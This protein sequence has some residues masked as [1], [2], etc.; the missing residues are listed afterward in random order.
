MTEIITTLQEPVTEPVIIMTDEQKRVHDKVISNIQAGI[1][2]TITGG[3][4]VGKTTLIKFIFQ[5]LASMGMLG[6]LMTAPTHQAKNVLAKA[7]GRDVST[8]HSAL[9]ISPVTNEEIRTFEQVR[10]KKAPDL[11]ECR[12]FIVEEVSMVDIGLF[13]IIRKSL[14]PRCVIL[15]LGDR[16]QIRPVN[17]DNVGELSP[18]FDPDIFDI[19]VMDTVM[20]QAEDNPIIKVSRAIRDGAPIAPLALGEHG[21]FQH[22]DA[23]S[24]LMQYFRT[25]KTPDDLF[26]N[27]M[28][29]YTNENVDK[30]NDVIRRNLYKTQDPF[31]VNEIIVMQEPL[32]EEATIGGVKF[33]EIIYNNNEQIRV[34]RITKRTEKLRAKMC[35]QTVDIDYYLLNTTSVEEEIS[36][37]IRVIVDPVMRERFQEFLSYVA[38]TYKRYKQQ[39]GGKAPWPVFWEIKNKFHNVKPLPVCTYHKAQGS[40]YDNGFMYTRDVLAFAD[41]DLCK[42]LLYVG[43]TRARYRVDYV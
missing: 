18:F 42:Q 12:V 13:R 29:A 3:P 10:G 43:V 1:H 34:D 5:S 38:G 14:P 33:T 15:G 24:F 20:R 17:S 26:E 16:D 9:K 8:I 6:M 40:T 23:R 30:L 32:V 39:T 36:S 27:R 41:Y 35:D 7:S 28:F 2:T 22:Q 21:V 19:L 31:I 11:S 25:V 4:G 37:E